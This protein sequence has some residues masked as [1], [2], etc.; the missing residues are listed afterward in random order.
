MNKED[1]M[2]TCRLP[3]GE[4]SFTGNVDLSEAILEK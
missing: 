3:S 4:I 2:L 1:D